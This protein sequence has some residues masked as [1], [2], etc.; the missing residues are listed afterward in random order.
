MSNILN[1]KGVKFL[2]IIVLA[3]AILATFGIVAVQ[4]ADAACSITTTLRQGST[5]AEVVCLQTSLGG[6]T[7]DGNFGPL[8]RAAVVNWQSISGLTPDGV[9]GPLSRAVWLANA[10]NS[11]NF[12]SG[13]SSAVGYSTTTGMPCSGGISLPAGCSSAGGY[14]VTTGMPCSGGINLPAG[15]TS[16]AGYSP[17][18]GTKCDNTGSPSG[19]L[20][21]GAGS[22]TVTS[23]STYSGEKIKA[24][25]EDVKVLGL[26]IEADDGSD[27]DI[28]SLK[29]ELKQTDTD[30]SQRITDYADSV[31][32]WMGD[33]QVGSD[34]TSDFSESNDIYTKSVS[35]DGAIIRAGEK[36]KFYIALSAVSNLDSGDIDDENFSIDV[37]NQR[38]EDGEGVV[39]TD[40]Q[41]V[42]AREADFE[43]LATSGDIDV[44]ITK[45]SSSPETDTVVI[46]DDVSDTNDVLLLA[47]N[48]KA[49]GSDIEVDDL[50]FDITPT[51]A[52]ANL[53][54]KEYKLEVDGEEIATLA[55]TSIADAATGQIQFVDMKEDFAVEAGETVVVKLLADINDTEGTDF[56]DSDSILASLTSTNFNL[57]NTTIKDVNGD[58]IANADRTGSITGKTLSFYATGMIVTH[59][60]SVTADAVVFDTDANAADTARG[61]FK[62]RFTVEAV[63]MDVYLDKGL[64]ES[65]STSSTPVGT[66]RVL[67]I[68]TSNGESVTNLIGGLNPVDSSDVTV[69]TNT[70]MIADGDTVDF[71]LSVSSDVNPDAEI[72]AVLSALEWGN[73]DTATGDTVYTLNM[74]VTGSY[75]SPAITVSD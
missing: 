41:A 52:N 32:V 30:S 38:F 71:V 40:T 7:P 46:V 2:A 72:Q 9:F 33:D 70:Y 42:T 24:G 20:A 26:E 43:D 47:V 57:T 61:D 56:I 67:V 68:T 16:T 6:L 15:C 29:I 45:H 59:I 34:D 74:G 28:S 27:V 55:V 73:A 4:Q 64:S 19:P 69:G 44:K 37:L 58:N 11:A 65:S 49:T 54:V 36:A 21:G 25:E 8:T 31:S 3:V 12:P 35:L 5:G 13:C 53:I 75:K 1:L 10:G 17:T 48:L 60:A 66:N 63:G 51:G 18:T 22:I 50:A 23:L 62:I 39:S 14:S